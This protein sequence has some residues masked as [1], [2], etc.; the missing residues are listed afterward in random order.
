MPAGPD[1][2]LEEGLDG[3]YGARQFERA[4][5]EKMARAIVIN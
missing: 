1:N 4:Q 5:L 3:Q 2:P